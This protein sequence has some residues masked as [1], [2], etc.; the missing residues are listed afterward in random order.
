MGKFESGTLVMAKSTMG[1]WLTGGKVY[2]IMPEPGDDPDGYWEHFIDDTGILNGTTA[3]RFTIVRPPQHP[4][5]VPEMDL[6][7]I[8]LAQGLVGDERR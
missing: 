8:H 6:D 1:N 7:E 3:D 2:E 4:M 5:P